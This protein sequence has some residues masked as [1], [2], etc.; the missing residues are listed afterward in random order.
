MN[1]IKEKKKKVFFFNLGMGGFKLRT[2]MQSQ[3]WYYHQAMLVLF[4]RNQGF[5]FRFPKD[6]DNFFF[7]IVVM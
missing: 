1:L 5:D 3:T 7:L 6:Q 2:L 4:M